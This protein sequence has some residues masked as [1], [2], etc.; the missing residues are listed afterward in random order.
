[1]TSR[2]HLVGFDIPGLQ[3][4]VFAP[5]RPLDVMGGSRFA[6]DRREREH[7]SYRDNQATL[8]EAD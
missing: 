2:G 1:M 4:Y 7:A 8:F 3:R 5:V 6:V